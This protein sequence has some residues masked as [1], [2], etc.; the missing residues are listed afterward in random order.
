MLLDVDEPV[1]AIDI[2]L[3]A[4]QHTLNDKELAIEKLEDSVPCRQLDPPRHQKQD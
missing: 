4:Q 2:D 1:N 3:L